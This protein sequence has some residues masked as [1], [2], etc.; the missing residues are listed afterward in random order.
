MGTSKFDIV[1]YLDSKEMIAEYLNTVLEEGNSA[2]I[3]NAIG[4]VAKAIGMTKIA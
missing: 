3:I 1:D 2:D 4:H